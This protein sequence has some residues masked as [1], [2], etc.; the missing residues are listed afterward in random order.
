M[1]TI[2]TMTVENWSDNYM[3]TR[4]K[5]LADSFVELLLELG[6]D[7]WWFVC[8]NPK[9]HVETLVFQRETP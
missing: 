2:E 9:S 7:G 8:F 6:K 5:I 1:K 3:T 4:G